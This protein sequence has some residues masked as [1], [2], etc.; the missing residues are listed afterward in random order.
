MLTDVQNRLLTDHRQIDT[1][2]RSSA[3]PFLSGWTTAHPVEYEHIRPARLSGLAAGSLTTYD[4]MADDAALKEKIRQFH[5]TVDGGLP[6]E[7]DIF[8]GA[9]SSPFI[10]S[11]MILWSLLGSRNVFYVR[12][13]YHA[14][15][16]MAQSLGMRMTGIGGNSLSADR[17]SVFDDLPD[18]QIQLIVTDPSWISGRHLPEAFWERLGGWQARTGSL[19][20]VDGT[21]QYT[22][23]SEMTRE[24]SSRLDPRRTFRLVCPTKSLCLHGIRFAYL[25]LP[26]EYADDLAYVY[27]KLVASTSAFDVRAAHLLMDQL[28][29]RTNNRDLVAYIR[30]RYAALRERLV[31]ETVLEPDCSY[32]IFAKSSLSLPDIVSMNGRYFELSYPDDHIRLN[33]LSPDLSIYIGEPP[34]P[35]RDEAGRTGRPRAVSSVSSNV[36]PMAESS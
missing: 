9:G 18:E 7:S 16:F 34:H 10:S 26:H 21:F 30:E 15:Y 6:Q 8:L 33:I 14:Y 23:W 13:I 25:I 4:F 12:P 3:L 36:R 29:S 32:Y 19:V 31:I 24:L 1:L 2:A 17:E 20:L 22:R 5:M 11:M 35:A 27:C 28:N